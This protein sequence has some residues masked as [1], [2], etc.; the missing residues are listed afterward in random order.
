MDLSYLYST[1]T[2]NWSEILALAVATLSLVISY[3]N[4][5][6]L[7]QYQRFEYGAHLQYTGEFD[8]WNSGVKIVGKVENK[9]MKPLYVM[10]LFIEY[11]SDSDPSM[12]VGDWVRGDFYLSPGD[13]EEIEFHR[14]RS[15]IDSVMKG[16]HLREC[17]FF[18]KIAY[19]TA[20]E[21]IFEVSRALGGYSEDGCVM[22][23]SHFRPL[24]ARA[25]KLPPT[26]K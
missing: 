18:L 10:T 25:R 20:A 22:K 4:H 9:G 24:Y 17:M 19:R 16:L 13:F 12:R 14:T 2:A 23:V 5:R 6:M 8:R 21:D 26:F 3:R 15:E 1:I 11:G 7:S